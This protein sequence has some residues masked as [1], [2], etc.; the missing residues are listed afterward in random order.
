MG[1]QESDLNK[2]Y[3]SSETGASGIPSNLANPFLRIVAFVI[4]SIILGVV[5]FLFLVV[6]GFSMVA[7]GATLSPLA[8]ITPILFMIFAI[9]YFLVTEGMMWSAS[10]GKKIVG[11]KIVKEDGSNL[12]LVTALIRLV[13]KSILFAIPFVNFLILLASLFF[14]FTSPKKQAIHDMI[15]KTYVVENK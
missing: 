12:D 15:V 2:I 10:P 3:G 11:I 14:M 6:S 13:V 7:G 8:A 1:S 4:D 5:A 9:A